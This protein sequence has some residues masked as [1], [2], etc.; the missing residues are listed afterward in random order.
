MRKNSSDDPDTDFGFT[1]LPQ[2]QKAR[3]V[4][5][6]FT[7]VAP[8]YD[9]MN[10][11]MSL[12]IHRVW[13]NLT[14]T[15]LNPQPGECLLDVA[16]GTGDLA[17]RVLQR[18]QHT[19]RRQGLDFA[20]SG[21]RAII[22]DNNQ[23]M[24]ACGTKAD[25]TQIYPALVPQ[26]LC[27]DAQ[28]LPFDIHVSDAITIGFGIRNVVDRMA[29]LKEFFRVLKPGGRLFILEFSTPPDGFLRQFYDRYSFHIIPALGNLLAR[30][31]ASYQYLVESIRRFPHQSAFAK[32]IEEAGFVHVGYQNFSGGIAALHW[33]W[34]L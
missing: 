2:S 29:A 12:G 27:A 16:G 8:K 32:M 21:T 3:E 7:A 17:R 23:A 33:G 10:D 26:R 31:K 11:V 13:K 4:G 5:A 30:D 19:C 20:T 14:I 15:R 25:R 1:D 24:I 9:L 22:C 34:K 6:V 18:V 28:S